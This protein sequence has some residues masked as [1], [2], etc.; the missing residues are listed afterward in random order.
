MRTFESF[1]NPVYRLFFCGMVGFMA[2]MNMEQLARS[3]LI[4]RITGSATILSLMALAHAIPILCLSLFGGVIADRMQKKYVL[5]AA[6]AGSAVVTFG[7]ALSLTLGYLSSEHAGSWWILIVASVLK[8]TIQGLMMPSRQAIVREIVSQEQLTNAISLNTLEMNALRLLA[9]AAAGFLIDAYDFAVV[10]YISVSLYLLSMVFIALMPRTRRITIRRGGTIS[11]IIEGLSYIRKD[12]TILIILI[13]TALVIVL[14]MPYQM[15]LPIFTEDIL[16]V[17]AKELGILQ[18]IAGVGAIG[19]SIAL[20]SMPNKKRG[21]VLLVSCLALGLALVGFSFSSS[22]YPSLV[23]I[24]FVG[25]GQTGRMALS[26]TLLQYYTKDEY[27]GRV[28]SFYMMEFGL[29]SLGTFGAGLLTESM[30]VQWAVGGFAI[31]LVF[32]SISSLLF[33]PRIRRLD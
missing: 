15:L 2:P 31:L 3:L 11:D 20:A 25:L 6:Q 23:L 32:L 29:S 8:A 16:E 19:G 22:W 14:S 13:F 12:I 26:N 18:S 30:G 17:G 21:V 27:R 9:P 10:Y 5:L 24:A 28:M 1:K 7:I 4:Y 33:L